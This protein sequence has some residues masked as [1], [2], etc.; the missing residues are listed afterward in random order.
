MSPSNKRY[1][2]CN[3]SADFKLIST[4]L[5]YVLEQFHSDPLNSQSKR[6]SL[7]NSTANLT[8]QTPSSRSDV[9]KP[10]HNSASVDLPQ[11]RAASI[12]KQRRASSQDKQGPALP[13]ITPFNRNSKKTF[14]G[15]SNEPLRKPL[16]FR[17][18]AESIPKISITTPT[19]FDE[20]REESN[21]STSAASSTT[22]ASF[23]QK[24]LSKSQSRNLN[25][26]ES[27]F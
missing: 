2:I 19:K 8:R 5:I 11:N 18:M 10:L 6:T 17:S 24:I 15:S 1:V 9:N 16:I 20:I 13:S 21:P 26:N 12:T 14:D 27:T 3:P 7:N 22:A 23:K 4:D 25:V